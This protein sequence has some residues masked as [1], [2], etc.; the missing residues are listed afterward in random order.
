MTYLSCIYAPRIDELV[1]IECMM[2]DRG[3]NEPVVALYALDK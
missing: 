3:A 1:L 2:L